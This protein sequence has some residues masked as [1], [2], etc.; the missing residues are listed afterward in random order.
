MRRRRG[1][2]QPRQA[3]PRL[4]GQPGKDRL[5]RP[6]GSGTNLQGLQPGGDRRRARRRQ[7]SIC[8]GEEGRRRR[9]AGPTGAARRLRR[10]PRAR[11]ARR[12]DV[13]RQLQAGLP[14]QAVSEGH[15]ARERSRGGQRRLDAG[16]RRRRSAA[17]CADRV[18]RRRSRLR[19]AGDG[20]GQDG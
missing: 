7:R 10:K 2:V 6:I 17:E 19:G 5:H 8:A 16:Q 4:D 13:D 18:R 3:D 11:S 20:A 15:A 1:G 14:R 12:A 9:S